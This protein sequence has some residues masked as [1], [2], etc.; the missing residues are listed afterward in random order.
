ME[1]FIVG[2]RDYDCDG[3]TATPCGLMAIHNRKT[4]YMELKFLYL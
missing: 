1:T 4:Q 2:V 3:T